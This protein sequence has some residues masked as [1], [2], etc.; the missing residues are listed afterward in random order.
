MIT[1]HKFNGDEFVLNANQIEV[2][3]KTPDTIITLMNDKKYLVKETMEEVVN[4]S[5]EYYNRIQ[6]GEKFIK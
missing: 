6:T 4:R 2:I 1:L 5:I 3:E